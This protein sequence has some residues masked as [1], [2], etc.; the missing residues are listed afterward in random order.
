MTATA[1]FDVT[2]WEST[3]T[4][5]PEEGPTQTRVAITKSFEGDLTGTSAGEGLFCGLEAPADGAGY[6]VSERFTGRLGDREGTFVMQHGG[7]AAPGAEPE[8][9]GSVVPGSGTGALSGMSGS[10]AF[11]AS[12][13]LTL[14][15]QF[16]QGT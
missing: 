14:D 13:I 10:V 6:L 12:H 11:G 15:V 4:D 8:S 5:G 3:V 2:S 9:F 16:D 1:R 7:L